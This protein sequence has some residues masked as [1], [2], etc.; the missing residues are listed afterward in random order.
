MAEASFDQARKAFENFLSSAQQ[1][2]SS[3]EGRGEAVRAGAKQMRL[4]PRA[5]HRAGAAR[6]P[7]AAFTRRCA[8]ADGAAAADRRAS[9]AE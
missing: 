3:L 7:P 8:R 5:A 2:A 6:A 9:I 4:Q 1:A